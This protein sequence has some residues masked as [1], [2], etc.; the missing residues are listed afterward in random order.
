MKT[1]AALFEKYIFTVF[2]QGYMEY[3]ECGSRSDHVKFITLIGNTII[4]KETALDIE[5]KRIEA[6]KKA[7]ESRSI[8]RFLG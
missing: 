8:F 2:Q 4:A 6:A 7:E 3:T 1:R 5:K